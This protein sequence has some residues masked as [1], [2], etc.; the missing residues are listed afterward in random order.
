M[1]E[2]QWCYATCIGVFHKLCVTGQQWQ[3]VRIPLSKFTPRQMPTDGRQCWRI[4]IVL[5]VVGRMATRAWLQIQLYL[6]GILLD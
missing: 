1:D 4:L 2:V 6:S 3:R 5:L